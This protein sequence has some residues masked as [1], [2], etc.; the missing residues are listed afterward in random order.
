MTNR[1]NRLLICVL[2]LCGACTPNIYS[3][4]ARFA[5]LDIP[6]TVRRGDHA[7][8]AVGGLERSL[9]SANASFGGVTYRTGIGETLEAGVDATVA[10]VGDSNC[11]SDSDC[12][13]TA[14]P[15]IDNV[16]YSGR[17]Q[18][19]WSIVPGKVSLVSGLGGGHNFDAGSYISPDLGV[20]VGYPIGSFTPFGGATMFFSQPIATKRVDVSFGEDPRGSR[21]DEAAQTLG[22]YVHAGV[23]YSTPRPPTGARSRIQYRMKFGVNAFGLE[24][25]EKSPDN[26]RHNALG[27][28]FQIGPELVF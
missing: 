26:V 17:A 10:W 22:W 9:D 13:S 25:L 21:W 15:A 19:K 18:V 20:V 27:L 8:S 16:V 14:D 12:S 4:P 11:D 24:E 1:Q 2:G 7:I 6:E 23:S 5:L 28:G 3:P